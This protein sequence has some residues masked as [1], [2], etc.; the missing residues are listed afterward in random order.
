MDRNDKQAMK[1][2]GEKQK[3]NGV[4]KRRRMQ[5]RCRKRPEGRPES[6]AGEG[7]TGEEYRRE[8]PGRV[9]G[10]GY[11]RGVPERGTGEGTGKGSRDTSGNSKKGVG[12]WS[13]KTDGNEIQV[14]EEDLNFVFSVNMTVYK[15][16]NII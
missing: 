6:G 5:Q 15:S 13:Q 9:N 8:V 2:G 10:K 1:Q 12:D 3:K 7:C 11:R 4:G 16:K 14:S